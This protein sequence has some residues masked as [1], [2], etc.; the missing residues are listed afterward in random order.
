MCC[1]N[2]R[3]DRAAPYTEIDAIALRTWTKSVGLL[4][5]IAYPFFDLVFVTVTRLQSGR[6]VWTP[7]KDHTTHRLNRLLKSARLTALAVYALTAVAVPCGSSG[8]TPMPPET[9]TLRTE[10][11]S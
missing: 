2:V 11:S 9:S 5:V 8:A 1:L 6:P 10:S 7:G 4:L 3:Q